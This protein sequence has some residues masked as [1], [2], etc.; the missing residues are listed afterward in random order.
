[1]T[2]YY[3]TFILYV[4]FLH[5]DAQNNRALIIGISKY[6]IGSG[7]EEIHAT[8]DCRLL[9]HLLSKHNFEDTNKVLLMDDKATKS[10]ILIQLDQLLHKTGPGD[11]L[12]IHFSCHGQQM[13]D[14]N[15][16]EDDGLDEALIPYDARF[17]YSPGKYEG[18]NHLGDDEIGEWLYKLRKKTGKNGNITLV[19]DA[20]HSGT[21]NREN[22]D[23]DYIRGTSYIF[24]PENYVPSPGKHQER[25][26]KLKKE[27]NLA[28]ANVFSACNPGEINYEFYDTTNK[29]YYGL[30]TY[31]FCQTIAKTSDKSNVKTFYTELKKTMNQLRKN[32]KK[33]QTPYFECSDPKA[34]FQ[35]GLK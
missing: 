4:F 25:S 32:K 14:S 15:G 18:E 35:I 10:N 5:T 28:P 33:I 27:K 17:W 9:Q 3:L 31:A 19:I 13:M 11:Y 24:A 1:M 6:P 12:Y 8:E 7:W 26:L 2:R 34:N 23:E 30:L 20:C 29:N 21:A 16:D 22:E